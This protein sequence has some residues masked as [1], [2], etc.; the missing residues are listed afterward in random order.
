[1]S[2]ATDAASRRVRAGSDVAVDRLGRTKRE[3]HVGLLGG[4]IDETKRAER[5]EGDAGLLR[6]LEQLLA[7]VRILAAPAREIDVMRR[8]VPGALQ[9]RQEVRAR[10]IHEERV[11]RKEGRD[12]ETLAGRRVLAD[13]TVDREDD[14]AIDRPGGS[15]RRE[16]EV[17]QI[18]DFVAPE[19]H[20]DGVGHAE[21][22]HVEDAAAETEL[23]DIVHH[24]HTLE[25]DAL[26]V[27]RELAWS[28]HVPLSE[29]DAQFFERAR[30][31][32]ALEKRSRRR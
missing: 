9:L 3:D 18:D 27:R 24:R 19:L 11:G 21:R 31:A 13:L 25:S 14:G 29:L 26:E 8:L 15:L 10:G 5:G 23:R 17:A 6:R 20:P 12:G 2:T 7:R 28:A 30:Q 22:V 16:L 1:V 32:R 4:G